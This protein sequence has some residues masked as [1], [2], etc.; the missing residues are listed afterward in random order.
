MQEGEN[1]EKPRLKWRRIAAIM[2]ETSEDDTVYIENNLRTHWRCLRVAERKATDNA[3]IKAVEDTAEDHNEADMKTGKNATNEGNT[4]DV[5]ETDIQGL[6]EV[7]E[8]SESWSEMEREA[9][10]WF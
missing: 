1:R 3:A 9:T 2:T 10:V 4:Q 6:E 5:G 7:E 8:P